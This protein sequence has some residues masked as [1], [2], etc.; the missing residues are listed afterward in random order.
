[1]ELS[2]LDPFEEYEN[3]GYLRNFFQE[4]D[5]TIV[6]H[7]ETAAFEDHIHEALRSLRRLPRID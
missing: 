1:M 7:L 4:K 3:A 2:I 6:G 5:L